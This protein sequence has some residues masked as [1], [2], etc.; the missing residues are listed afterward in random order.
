MQLCTGLAE[1]QCRS[2]SFDDVLRRCVLSARQYLAV[3][4]EQQVLLMTRESA[5]SKPGS[6]RLSWDL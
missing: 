1:R 3:D 2:F 5:L 4:C 6:L